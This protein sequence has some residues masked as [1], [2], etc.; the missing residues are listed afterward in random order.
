MESREK[1]KETVIHIRVP[2]LAESASVVRHQLNDLGIK[3]NGN[4]VLIGDLLLAVGEAFAN[5]VEH[6]KSE[7]PIEI[8]ARV[9]DGVITVDILDH[10]IGFAMEIHPQ[11]ADPL[12]ERGRGL[13][14]MGM[15]TESCTV[16]SAPGWGARVTIQTRL[17][18]ETEGKNTT[19]V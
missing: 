9:L 13:A 4:K 17:N 5:A 10:G 7:K 16:A 12:S 18:K 15:L 6:G 8:E 11:Q 1:T 19:E 3:N 2:N 14:L